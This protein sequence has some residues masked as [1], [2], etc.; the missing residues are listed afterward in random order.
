MQFISSNSCYMQA[1]KTLPRERLD[2]SVLHP[3]AHPERS[4]LLYT[5]TAFDTNT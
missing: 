5:H 1:T 2:S 4:A 3:L